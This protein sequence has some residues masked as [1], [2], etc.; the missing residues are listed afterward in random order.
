VDA[1]RWSAARFDP[2][3]I[4]RGPHHLADAIDAATADADGDALAIE[5]RLAPHRI[6][7]RA[8]GGPGIGE[9]MRGDSRFDQ[10]LTRQRGIGS[11][12]VDHGV[13]PL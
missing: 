8:R 7:L 2:D 12:S 13:T 11:K 5:P 9:S 4:G 6:E 3:R 10:N 1:L